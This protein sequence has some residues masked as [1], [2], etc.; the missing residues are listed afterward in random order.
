M[1]LSQEI[2]AKVDRGVPTKRI[3]SEY[4]WQDLPR[5]AQEDLFEE[6]ERRSE[7]TENPMPLLRAL[8]GLTVKKDRWATLRVLTCVFHNTDVEKSEAILDSM[9]KQLRGIRDTL[10]DSN[11][12]EVDRYMQYLAEYYVLEAHRE[13]DAGNLDKAIRSYESA[14]SRFRGSNPPASDRIALV[15]QDLARLRAIQSRSQSL[16]PREALE[17]RTLRLQQDLSKRAAEL[18]NLRRDIEKGVTRRDSLREQC[19][20][21]KQE[22]EGYEEQT[23]K[24]TQLR[25][26]IVQHETALQFLTALPRVAMAPLWV[27]V[28]RLALAQGEIDVFTRSAIERLSVPHPEEALPLLVEIIAR[29]PDSFD[30]DRETYEACTR[31]WMGKIAEAR[32]L[33]EEKGVRDAAELLVVAWEDYF[34][35][36]GNDA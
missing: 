24:L 32:R 34:D 14:L 1:T 13:I 26:D 5:L 22:M 15:N 7:T 29:T 35:A 28:V 17:S 8:Y 36:L 6:A 16:V 30:I 11:P 20:T 31:H 33:K 9:R 21:L 19:D 10:S 27:E 12:G 25:A 18:Q 23:A 2:I 4:A 3:V